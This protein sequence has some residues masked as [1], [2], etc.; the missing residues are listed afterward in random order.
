MDPTLFAL[1]TGPG[2]TPSAS[3]ALGVVLVQAPFRTKAAED[4]LASESIRSYFS[5]DYGKRDTDHIGGDSLRDSGEEK[6]KVVK[7][8]H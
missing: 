1:I 2:K 6:S 4:S 5:V 3:V 7:L 8:Q